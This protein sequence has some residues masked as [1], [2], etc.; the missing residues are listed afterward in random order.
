MNGR[1]FEA[2]VAR[3]EKR[4]T[5]DLYHSA[6]VVSAPEGTFVI[7]MAPVRDGNGAGAALSPK[8]LSAAAGRGRCASS[9]T[10]SDAGV[11]V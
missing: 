10:K 3:L 4:T 6:L 11:R 7:E 2:V 9:G 1:I 8:L 5:C